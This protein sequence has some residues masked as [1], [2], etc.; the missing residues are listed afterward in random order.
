MALYCRLSYL[1][2]LSIVLI[3]GLILKAIFN[4]LRFNQKQMQRGLFLPI[5]IL[6]IKLTES[7]Q[8]AI[9]DPQSCVRAHK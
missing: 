4:I 5:Y 1:Q 8:F 6:R 7:I 2:W 3:S 9:T